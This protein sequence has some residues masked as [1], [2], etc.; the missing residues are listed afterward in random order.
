MSADCQCETILKYE[1][2]F[3]VNGLYGMTFRGAHWSLDM[4]VFHFSMQEEDDIELNLCI[5]LI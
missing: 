4:I 5:D 1:Q 2:L 3:K